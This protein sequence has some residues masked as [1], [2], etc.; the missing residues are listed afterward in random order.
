MRSVVSGVC[1]RL[2]GRRDVG[3]SR[4]R[5]LR[6][7]GD[8]GEVILRSRERWGTGRPAE[9]GDEGRATALWEARGRGHTSRETDGVGRWKSRKAICVWGQSSWE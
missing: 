1:I 7:R 4:I 2:L 8:P 9:A 6:G 3:I 5:G